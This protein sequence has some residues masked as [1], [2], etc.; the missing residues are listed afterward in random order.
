M[1]HF[2]YLLATLALICPLKSM[3]DELTE[4]VVCCEEN[5][6]SFLIGVNYSRLNFKPDNLASLNGNLGGLQALYE[7]RPAN[8]FYAG[9]E[10]SWRQGSIHGKDG[11][12]EL[13]DVNVAERLGYT[14]NCDCWHVTAYTGFGF[15]FLGHHVHPSE[16]APAIFI[17]SFFP[18]FLT[19]EASLHLDY[20]EFY[21][22]LGFL[23]EY[24][25]SEFFSLG[26]NF[27]WMPQAFSTVNI[28][29][30]GGTF[31]SLTNTYANF[32]I[33]MPFSF[34][35]ACANTFALVLSPFYERW[36]DGHSTAKSSNGTPLG[37]EGDTY[38]YYGANLNF[39]Y[40]F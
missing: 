19:D 26:L 5:N 3:G 28:R 21:V 2:S 34:N 10:G 9:I 30:L 24:P 12:R 6:S 8:A 20:F 16:E 29:P 15:R 37:L 40:R 25:F 36:Q 35:F 27:A 13:T 23:S 31:W 32:R 39:I 33:E 17:G 1:R 14:W 7:Y 22:P 18:P 4:E 38:N 11:K